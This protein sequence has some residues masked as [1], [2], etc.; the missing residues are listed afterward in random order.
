MFFPA[1]CSSRELPY[2]VK[3]LTSHTRAVVSARTGSQRFAVRSECNGMNRAAVAS[4]LNE[5]LARGDVPQPDTA[6]EVP[7]ASV[8]PS[9]ENA[10]AQRR[11]PSTLTCP[12]RRPLAVSQSRMTFGHPFRWR[13]RLTSVRPAKPSNR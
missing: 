12:R 11:R 9:G 2:F 1:G 4:E 13:S 3:R 10:A 6:T 5:D 7:L 8:S